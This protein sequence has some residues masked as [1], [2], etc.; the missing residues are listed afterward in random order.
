MGALIELGKIFQWSTSFDVC[1][2]SLHIRGHPSGLDTSWIES[3]V[4]SEKS[5]GWLQRTNFKRQENKVIHLC[6]RIKIDQNCK[7]LIHLPW[8]S[9]SRSMHQLSKV[10]PTGP[11]HNDFN[12]LSPPR[13][14]VH[15]QI[16]RICW[17]LTTT[18][19]VLG[20]H[21]C[22]H[23]YMPLQLQPGHWKTFW[24]VGNGS[25]YVNP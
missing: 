14:L 19:I 1:S 16:H 2:F 11:C 21:Y 7:C 20:C 22:W 25:S 17:N 24:W 9:S 5:M 10:S 3:F 4:I 23:V 12:S 13:A 18:D 8:R 6:E 15:S